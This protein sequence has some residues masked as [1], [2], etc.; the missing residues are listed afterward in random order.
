M[1]FGMKP[2]TRWFG[3]GAC[4]AM[5]L[6]S[7]G[8]EKP[9]PPP[10]KFDLPLSQPTNVNVP[11]KNAPVT[12]LAD[13]VK[14]PAAQTP[15]AQTPTTQTP[16]TPPAVNL[17]PRELLERT[18]KAYASARGY[19]DVAYIKQSY[20][21]NGQPYEQRQPLVIAYE[22]PNKLRLECYNVKLVSDGQQVHGTIR[23]KDGILEIAAPATLTQDTVVLDE[24]MQA[25]LSRGF[26]SNPLQLL[27][28]FAPDALSVV[29]GDQPATFV[30]DMN[31]NGQSCRRVKITTPAGDLVLW[32]DPTTYVVRRLDYPLTDLQKELSKQGEIKKLEQYADFVGAELNPKFSEDTFKFEVPKGAQLVKRFLSVPAPLKPTPL[33]GKLSPQFEFKTVKGEKITADSLTDK[34]AV[35]VFWGSQFPPCGT[36]L[37]LVQQVYDYYHD[38]PAVEFYAI[39]VDEANI[40]QSTLDAAFKAWNVS[41]PIV[42]DPKQDANKALGVDGVPSVLVLGKKGLI[43]HH[44]PRLDNTLPQALPNIINTLLAGESTHAATLR[45]YEQR[46]AEYQRWQQTPPNTDPNAT[47]NIPLASATIAAASAPQHH[48]LETAWTIDAEKIKQPGNVFVVPG[49]EPTA[50]RLL[51]LDGW[52]AVV[53]VDLSGAIV[54]RHELNLPPK[55]AVTTIRSAVDRAGDRYYVLFHPY[56][57]RGQLYLYDKDWK[58]LLAYPRA[59]DLGEDRISDVQ[60]GDMTGDGTLKLIVG[61]SGTTGVQM[62][63]LTGDRLWRNREQ[64]RMS[65][66]MALGE[67]RDGTPR[68][69]FCPNEQG[70][71]IPLNAQGEAQPPWQMAGQ[72]ILGLFTGG[73]GTLAG[74]L[75]TS[76]TRMNV[77]GL[78]E[79]GRLL[80]SYE[81]PIGL[82]GFP[83]EYVQS[84]RLTDK[85]TQSWLLAGADGSVHLLDERGRLVD[86]Y[87]TGNALQGIAA[88][89]NAGKPLIVTVS[90]SGVQAQT[91]EPL[92]KELMPLE[93]L[94]EEK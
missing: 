88:T 54:A 19:S 30:P 13:P 31:H 93:K 44:W 85:P 86:R 36:A 2:L 63:S 35:L 72:K 10:V 76:E 55:T 9:S 34:V 61:Y 84:V 37:P 74:L 39:S 57:E 70:T 83:I 75:P 65:L 78:G 59:D 48:K 1:N 73:E 52:N 91:L 32:I 26:G 8:C 53:E 67:P 14:A 25:E 64:I 29:L 12:P 58:Q 46:L 79:A 50:T 89:A 28:L 51:V 20:L 40:D 15:V 49:A 38:N 16:P 21:L 62:V 69:V 17:S 24:T 45:D 68:L 71:V 60:L 82:H 7:A 66:R 18:V 42:R 94:P 4:A 80:W 43:E 11:A 87:N 3:C 47:R 22:K 23:D 81:L 92:A 77:V 56:N 41:L 27:L 5:L 90:K 6:A 33:L